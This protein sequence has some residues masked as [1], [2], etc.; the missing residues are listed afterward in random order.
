MKKSSLSAIYSALKGID[1]DSEI[2]AEVEKELNKGEEKKAKNAEAYEAMHDVIV[3]ALSDTPVTC[4]ELF[5]SIEDELPEG[6]LK[7]WTLGGQFVNDEPSETDTDI[8]AMDHQLLS[9]TP[10]HLDWT[11][12]GSL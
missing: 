9:I 1:F 10:L 7:G 5:E 12:Y 3:G 2:L 8:W 6:V 4:A 11:D